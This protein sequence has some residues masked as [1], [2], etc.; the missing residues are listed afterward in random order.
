M[1]PPRVDG[2]APDWA[3]LYELAS[4]QGGRFTIEQALELGF[5]RQLVSHHLARGRFERSRRGIYAV[6]HLPRSEDDDLVL[7]WLWSGREGIFSHDTALWLHG[8]SDL[9]P[10]RRHLSVPEDWQARKLAVPRGLVLYYG[11]PPK[12]EREWKDILP[13]TTP[14]RTLAD[15]RA[16]GLSLDL[17]EQAFEEGIASGLLPRRRARALRKELLAT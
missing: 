16:A 12:K 5:S 15:C 13:V 3:A 8:L 14:L 2:T 4:S 7:D 9:L 10:R 6:A 1:F 17:L 11:L